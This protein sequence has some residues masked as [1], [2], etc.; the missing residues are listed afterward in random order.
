MFR[1]SAPSADF[2]AINALTQAAV[3]N[4]LVSGIPLAG[5]PAASLGGG[6]SVVGQTVEALG[7]EAHLEELDEVA[8]DLVVVDEGGLEARLPP[9]AAR[10]SQVAPDG[11]QQGVLA[12]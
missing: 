7:V 12:R 4:A 9:A 2:S 11:A 3:G 1:F 8:G 5:D 10:L 6:A